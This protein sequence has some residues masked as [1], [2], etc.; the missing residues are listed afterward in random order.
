[1][2]SLTAIFGSTRGAGDDSDKLL[3]LYRNRA[4][5]KKAFA[6]L[7]N[8]TF[9]LRKELEKREGARLR[10]EQKL[11]QLEGLLLDPDWMYSVVA[12]YQLRALNERCRSKLANFAEQ[13]KQQQE[14]KRHGRRIAGWNARRQEEI[15]ALERELDELRIVQQR[16]QGRLQSERQRFSAM[17]PLA[18]LFRKRSASRA[19]GGIDA[20]LAAAAAAETELIGKLAQIRARQAPDTPGLDIAS[21]RSINFMILS[22]A[23]QLY[24]HF[25][26]D[27]LASLGREAAAKS[28]G[29]VRY[30]TRDACDRLVASA[31][32]RI[33]SFQQAPLDTGTLHRRARLLADGAMF[34]GPDDAVPEPASVATLYQIAADGALS[35]RP[36]CLLTEDYWQLSGVLSR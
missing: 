26:P 15:A 28:A 16:L 33:R 11:D 4:E 32:A 6:R 3:A 17:G 8:E 13:I 12:F 31:G 22:F 24:L 29:T 27:D 7:E 14:R 2:T 36:L 10:L 5:L 9:R 21:K 1:M 18:R 25:A 35:T 19:L 20:E 34:A 30:G 23:Q